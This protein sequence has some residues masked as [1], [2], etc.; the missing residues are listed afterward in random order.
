MN[1]GQICDLVLN[2]KSIS[3]SINSFNRVIELDVAIGICDTPLSL[4]QLLYE[5]ISGNSIDDGDS[6]S[7]INMLTR[8]IEDC[9]DSLET[10]RKNNTND[11]KNLMITKANESIDNYDILLAS[12][13]LLE[14]AIEKEIRDA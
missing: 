7:S 12:I 13:T 5:K 1:I 10:N 4:F 3:I 9:I 11:L 2:F 14:D 8:S 6:N